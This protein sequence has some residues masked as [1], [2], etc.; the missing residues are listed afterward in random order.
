MNI[1]TQIELYLL[2]ARTWV[3]VRAICDRFAIPERSLRAR[4]KKAGPL[5]AFAFSHPMHGIIHHRYLPDPDFFRLDNSLGRQ[6]RRNVMTGKHPD[7]REAL[8]GQLILIP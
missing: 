8:S 7:L 3:S 6:A 1:K 5:D 4:G 2:A